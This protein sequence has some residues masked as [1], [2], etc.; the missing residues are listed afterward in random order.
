VAVVLALALSRLGCAWCKAVAAGVLYGV[1]DAA[2]KGVSVGWRIHGAGAL[3]SGWTALAAGATF[4][5]FLAFQAAL[6]DEGAVSSISLM[7]A[8]SAITGMSCGLLAFGESLGTDPLTVT[9]HL[10][11]IAVVLGCVPVLAAAQTALAASGEVAEE[12]PPLAA[13]LPAR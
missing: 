11:A 5:G 12:P 9:A 4:G 2:V 6:Q 13:S 8:V 3:V 10:L 1:A 7:T